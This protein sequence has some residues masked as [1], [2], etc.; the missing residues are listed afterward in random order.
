MARKYPAFTH[1][2]PAE[3]Q[4]AQPKAGANEKAGVPA[5]EVAADLADMMQGESEKQQAEQAPRSRHTAMDAALAE[6]ESAGEETSNLTT[7]TEI[8]T[9]DTPDVPPVDLA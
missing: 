9:D 6:E 4:S 3:A 8:E 5:S 7:G 1:V 2:V